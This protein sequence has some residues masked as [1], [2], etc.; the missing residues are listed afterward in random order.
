MLININTHKCID[1][2]INNCSL[3]SSVNNIGNNMN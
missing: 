2:V 3:I 1:S